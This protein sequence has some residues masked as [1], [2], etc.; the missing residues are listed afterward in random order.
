MRNP[1][2][3]ISPPARVLASSYLTRLYPFLSGCARLATSDG[4]ARLTGQT[5]FDT[6]SKVDGFELLVPMDDLVGRSIFF[7]GDLD[8]R[9]TQV[10]EQCV[11]PGDTVLD[12]GANLGLYSL[13]LSRLT[14]PAGQVHAFEPNPKTLAYLSRTLEKAAVPH[15]T[16]HKIALG[17]E[18]G[19]AEMET[20]AGNAGHAFLRDV[21]SSNGASGQVERVPVEPLS[22]YASE[23][24]IGAADFIKI[25][26]EGFEPEVFA[27]GL[28]Y[29][30][31][32]PP[33]AIVLEETRPMA[34]D[35][36]PESLNILSEIGFELFSIA[37]RRFLTMKLIREGGSG[38]YSP[39]DFLA[40]NPDRLGE[41]NIDALRPE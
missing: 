1:P 41:W 32:R 24:G 26:V 16:L 13:K 29:L 38:F 17:R 19:T 3:P 33:R 8:R 18:A 22:E 2:H 9:V 28:S 30:T 5:Q 11:K 10:V 4:L 34:E 6:W 23:R 39:G 21:Q 37:D 20:E 36:V 40:V 25:D 7:A 12:I 31:E 14:G 35:D 15:L 27:G